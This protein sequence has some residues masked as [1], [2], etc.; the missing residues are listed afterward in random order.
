[1]AFKKIESKIGF[2]ELAFASSMDKNRTLKTLEQLNKVIGWSRIEKIL[3]KYY[4]VGISTEGAD[5]YPPLMLFKC[6]LLQKW[7]RIPSDPELESQINDRISFKNFLKLPF[8][9]P[10]PDHSTFSRFRKRLSKKAM[11][12]I[13]SEVFKQFDKEG[14]SINE[15]IAL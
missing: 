13:N 4:K 7:F 2:A 14:L 10:S 1:M 9:M 5:A 3:K 12:K 6:L 15:G 11:I 8:D